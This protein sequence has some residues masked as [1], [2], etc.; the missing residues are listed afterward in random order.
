MLLKGIGNGAILVPKHWG[1]ADIPL[2]VRRRCRCCFA[3]ALKE[4]AKVLGG[5][6]VKDQF[7]G[8]RSE[9]LPILLD[10]SGQ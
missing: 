9:A 1:F 8:D 7:H 3:R 6:E 10:I 5:M 2:F 4:G